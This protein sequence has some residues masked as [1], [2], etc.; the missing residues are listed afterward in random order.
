MSG[1]ALPSLPVRFSLQP[2]T[3]THGWTEFLLSGSLT[4]QLNAASKILF[5]LAVCLHRCRDQYCGDF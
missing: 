2:Q 4:E 5:A 3:P 1:C